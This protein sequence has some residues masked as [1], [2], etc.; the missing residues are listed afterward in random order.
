M[1]NI[2]VVSSQAADD[3]LSVGGVCAS[4]VIYRIDEETVGISARSYGKTNV[5]V[6][7]EEM[8]GGGHLTMAACQIKV[9]DK[10]EAEYMLMSIIKK[11]KK[12]GILK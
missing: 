4:F 9:D 11:L 7:M 6:I 5:Q 3:L 2:R 8:G 10:E 1:E 12:K